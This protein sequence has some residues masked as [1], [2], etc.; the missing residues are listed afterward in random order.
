MAAGTGLGIVW[1]ASERKSSVGLL[2]M[3]VRQVRGHGQRSDLNA[4]CW[5]FTRVAAGDHCEVC[6]CR[7]EA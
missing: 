7:L 3:L 1:G 6:R 5:I 2:V 4:A